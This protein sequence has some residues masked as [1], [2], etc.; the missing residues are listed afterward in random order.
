MTPERPPERPAHPTRRRLSRQEVLD[1]VT[2]YMNGEKVTAIAHRY[3]IS[4]CYPGILASKA[5]V[6]LRTPYEVRSRQSESA[7]NRKKTPPDENSPTS[8]PE[9]GFSA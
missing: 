4:E 3:G 8:A 5:G 7:R 1:I 2:A 9:A 6:E